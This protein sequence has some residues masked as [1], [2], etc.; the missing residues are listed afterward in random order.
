MPGA[1]SMIICLKSLPNYNFLFFLCELIASYSCNGGN[2]FA[3]KGIA[4]FLLLLF[5]LVLVVPAVQTVLQDGKTVLFIV[6]EEKNTSLDEK[7]LKKEFAPGHT[8]YI[9]A[10]PASAPFVHGTVILSA[11]PFLASPGQPPNFVA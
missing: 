5:S 8:L 7:K 6:D 1:M 10:A 2:K 9:M 4:R 11:P 3:M